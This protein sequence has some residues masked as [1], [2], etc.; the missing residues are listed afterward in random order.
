MSLM[1]RRIIVSQAYIHINKLTK[2]LI[3]TIA[4]ALW[5]MLECWQHESDCSKSWCSCAKVVLLPD[6]RKVNMVVLWI[7]WWPTAL[8]TIYT[9][10]TLAIL[11]IQ[12]SSTSTSFVSWLVIHRILISI[13]YTYGIFMSLMKHPICYLF[14]SRT[15]DCETTTSSGVFKIKVIKTKGLALLNLNP[16]CSW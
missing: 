10:G 5:M 9:A 4:K 6:V 15:S 3:V 14:L 8:Q 16:S 1:H 2:I 12:L 7:L 13:N 11:C